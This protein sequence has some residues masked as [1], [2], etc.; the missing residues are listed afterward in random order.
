M[1]ATS[2]TSNQRNPS[3]NNVLI[4]CVLP[5][6]RILDLAVPEWLG[7]CTLILFKIGHDFAYI[8]LTTAN[9]NKLT[10]FSYILYPCHWSINGGVSAKIDQSL[11]PPSVY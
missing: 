10:S 5:L 2:V 6:F 1:G 8:F 9:Q 7:I 11:V 3:L 4:C